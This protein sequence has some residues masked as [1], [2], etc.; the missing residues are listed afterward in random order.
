MAAPELRQFGV[1]G[2]EDFEQHPV[3]ILWHTADYDKPWCG[4]EE[5]FRPWTEDLPATVL[6]ETL[7]VRA[8]FELWDGSH[9]PGFVTPLVEAYDTL[10]NG[11]RVGKGEAS[12]K[13]RAAEHIRWKQALRLLGRNNRN[14]ES[15]HNRSS[16]RLSVR[17]P[18]KYSR[19]NFAP[20]R[21]W[22]TA[23]SRAR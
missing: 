19:C 22:P 7:L 12:L 6:R 11:R 23:C 2:P 16:T 3:G 21:A 1:L 15:R 13:S 8:E 17:S 18:S 5:T 20:R 10:P 4:D 9:Y 14:F